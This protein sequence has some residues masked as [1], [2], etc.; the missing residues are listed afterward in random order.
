MILRPLVT[1]KSQLSF[2]VASEG[3][4]EFCWG[5]PRVFGWFS[6]AFWD[7][8]GGFE[9]RRCS[10][11]RRSKAGGQRRGGKLAWGEMI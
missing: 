2:A 9:F 7:W 3:F 8:R 6:D 10:E 11:Y 5:K 1:A 4:S